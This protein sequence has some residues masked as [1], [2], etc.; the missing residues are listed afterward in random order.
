MNISVQ[1]LIDFLEKDIQDWEEAAGFYESYVLTVTDDASKRT[2][3]MEAAKFQ[4]RV[5]ERKMLMKELMK[6]IGPTIQ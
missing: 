4:A 2:G 1:M 3:R 5:E 6:E